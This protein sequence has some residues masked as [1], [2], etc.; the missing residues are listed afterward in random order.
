MSDTVKFFVRVYSTEHASLW[1]DFVATSRNG[2]FLHMRSYLGYHADRFPDASLMLY[3]E[4]HLVALLPATINGSILFSHRGLTYGGLIVGRS[5]HANDAIPAFEAIASWALAKGLASLVYK[6]SPHIYHKMPA[7]EDLYAITRLGGR[8]VRRD[9]STALLLT[10]RYTYSKG[11]KAAIAKARR[12][13]LDIRTSDDYEAFMLIEARHLADKHGLTPVHTADEIKLLASRFP[14]NVKLTSAFEG[15]RMLGGVLTYTSHTV[16]H[17]QYIGATLEG[18]NLG[19]LDLCIDHI[20]NSISTGIRWF[21]FGISTTNT[22]LQL[23]E[24]LVGHKESWG[25]RTVVYDHYEL[26]F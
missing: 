26:R 19:A 20:L 21:D 22:G 14:A 3:A 23:D 6:P 25:G 17:A 16:C 12:G 13:N 24:A 10:E 18:K 2:T 15:E 7:E 5:F 1:D 11:R 9:L 8:L 4:D